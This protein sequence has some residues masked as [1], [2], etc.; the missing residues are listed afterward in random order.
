MLGE[1]LQ[2]ID[3]INALLNES[4]LSTPVMRMEKLAKGDCNALR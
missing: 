3:A 4:A 1:D 2:M